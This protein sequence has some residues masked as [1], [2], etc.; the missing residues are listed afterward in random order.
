MNILRE[1]PSPTLPCVHYQMDSNNLLG[2][3]EGLRHGQLSEDI[4][5]RKMKY[6]REYLAALDVVDAGI[7]H[8]RGITLWELQSVN[9]FLC[10]KR[11][12]VQEL[13]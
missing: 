1:I 7:S 12:Q 4:L 5:E 6:A 2:H 3:V 13:G 9:T 8:N 11:F 10:N